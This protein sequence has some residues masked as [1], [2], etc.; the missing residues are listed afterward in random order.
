MAGLFVTGTDTAA[1]KTVLSCAIVAALRSQGRSVQAFKPLITGLQE[2]AE[3]PWPHDHQL[4]AQLS[5]ADPEE[6]TLL[7]YGPPV[8]PH[9]AAEM[10]GQRLDPQALL[11]GIRDRVKPGHLTIVEGAGGLLVPIANGYDMRALAGDLG[12]P[13]LIAARPGLGTINHTLLTVEAARQAG[14]HVA[15]VVLT[16]W[17]SAPSLME[18]SNRATIEELAGLEVSV[19]PR[20]PLPDGGLLAR[21]GASLPLARWLP[22]SPEPT[23]VGCPE[24]TLVGSPEQTR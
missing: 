2:P 13:L 11:A 14:L 10:A 3:D 6:V 19:L 23:L 20:V 15:G 17:P 22:G 7:R 5:G 9:L 1:G 12:L 16:P 4:L 21:A 24:P 18:R 8:S